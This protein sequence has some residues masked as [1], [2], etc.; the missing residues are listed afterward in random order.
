MYPRTLA[1]IEIDLPALRL[2]EMRREERYIFRV[3]LVVNGVQ[4][5]NRIDGRCL[6]TTKQLPERRKQSLVMF[7]MHEPSRIRFLRPGHIAMFFAQKA[8]PPANQWQQIL[9]I[10]HAIRDAR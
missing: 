5:R 3:F 10:V 2:L 8:E 9:R 4:K 6:L 1:V 7:C